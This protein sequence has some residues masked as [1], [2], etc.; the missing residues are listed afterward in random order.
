MATIP[1]KKKLGRFSFKIYFFKNLFYL[2][3]HHSFPLTPK[4]FCLYKKRRISSDTSVLIILRIKGAEIRCQVER[5]GRLEYFKIS[6]FVKIRKERHYYEYINICK[7][8]KSKRE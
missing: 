1:I 8:T 6:K 7:C 2:Q 4:E 3:Y 5:L